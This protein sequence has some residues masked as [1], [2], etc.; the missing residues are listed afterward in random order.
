MKRKSIGCDTRSLSDF[1]RTRILK[2]W[3]KST[4][5]KAEYRHDAGLRT[6]EGR[7]LRF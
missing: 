4:T 5:A 1:A 3:S 6:L 2:A 7:H